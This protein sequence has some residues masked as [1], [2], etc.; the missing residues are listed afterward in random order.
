MSDIEDVLLV[1]DD[2]EAEDVLEHFG[3]KGMKWGVHHAIGPDGRVTSKTE[4]TISDDA[5]EVQALRGKHI[6]ELSNAE[7]RKLTQ[8]VDLETKYAKIHPSTIKKGQ[9]AVAS[10]IGLGTTLTTIYSLHNSKAFQAGYAIIGKAV[11]KI[12]SKTP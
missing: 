9:V 11:K 1:P 12:T 3:I 5:K 4:R 8:R 2:L 7:L 10:L 6:S